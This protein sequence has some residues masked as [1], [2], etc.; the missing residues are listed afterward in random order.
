MQ[1]MKILL[2]CILEIRFMSFQIFMMRFISVNRIRSFFRK[3]TKDN[4]RKMIEGLNNFQTVG[5]NK[6][7]FIKR[8]YKRALGARN[9]YHMIG[10]PTFR[11]LKM[12]ISQN[13]NHNLPVKVEDIEI[14]E[15]IFGPDVSNLKGRTTR[16]SPKFVVYNFIEIPIETI[17]NNQEL[18]PCMEI[19]FINQQAFFKT[20][21]KNIQF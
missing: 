21:D 12:I 14:T 9:I 17:E 15:K 4:K 5:E 11:N 13:I 20:I 7:G 16:H 1:E 19:M 3:A 8:H 2:G 18:I 10:A 6:K